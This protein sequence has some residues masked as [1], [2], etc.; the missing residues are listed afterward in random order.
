MGKIRF[1]LGMVLVLGVLW[2]VLNE[3]VSLARF[4]AGCLLGVLALYITDQFLLFYRYRDAYRIPLLWLAG[5]FLFLVVQIYLAGFSTMR[6]ILTGK[7][8]PDL[9]EIQTDIKN[10]FLVCLLANS[11]TL[12]PGTVTV[13]MSGRKLTVLWIDCSTKDP[14]AAGELIKGKLEKRIL[15]G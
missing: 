14:A 8:N 10:E 3:G 7:I 6:M 9:V 13:D 5:Y 1:Y 11:I 15:G 12:T 2:M 4:V